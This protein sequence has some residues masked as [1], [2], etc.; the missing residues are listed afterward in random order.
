MGVPRRAVARQ[1]VLEPALRPA[2]RSC[3]AVSVMVPS[4]CSV[5]R[6]RYAR[7]RRR[8]Q[9]APR[10][11]AAGAPSRRCRGAR[12]R[13]AART[14]R[15]AARRRDSSGWKATREQLALR[16]RRP[17][18]RRR[19]ARTSTPAPCSSIHGARMKTARTGPPSSPGSRG[20]PRRSAPGGRTRCA[21]P[22]MSM[23]PRCS[24]S[25]MISPAHVPSTGVAG[26]AER[27]AAAR[28]GPRARSRA[29]SSSTRRPAA[30]ARRGRRGRR[31]RAPRA[32]RRRA[33]RSSRACAVE[34]ALEGEDADRQRPRRRGPTSRGWRAP[35]LVEL[36]RLERLHRRAEALGR[37]RRRARGRRS[38]S[39]PRRSPRARV[40]GSS[41]LKIPEPTKTRL[42]AELHHQRG[43]GRRRDAAGAE[44]R[45]PAA[46]RPGRRRGRGRAAPAAPW[47]RS[48]SSASSSVPRRRISPRDRAQVAD[49]LDDVAGAG[50]ALGADHRRA[51]AD[52]PQRLAEVRRAAHERRP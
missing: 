6:R 11:Q 22:A 49:G 21:G 25:S 47:R 34:A 9:A 27:R 37:R 40:A 43:V 19:S 10:R 12:P 8:R 28:P 42:G 18:G 48:N 45:R 20:R 13:R 46:C 36:A 44:Q 33:S 16:A 39:S 51:L 30:R 4:R 38:A 31:A 1:E 24:R 2:V 14:P 15:A 50:L 41:D 7:A 3:V 5:S 32:P 17:D 29:S 23:T 35:A 52:A 26:G